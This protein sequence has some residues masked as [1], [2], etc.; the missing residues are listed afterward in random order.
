MGRFP[1]QIARLVNTCR[2]TRRGGI[3]YRLRLVRLVYRSFNQPAADALLKTRRVGSQ[4]KEL[5][6]KLDASII[7]SRA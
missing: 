4:R 3:T 5:Q 2:V 1:E 7:S 6:S